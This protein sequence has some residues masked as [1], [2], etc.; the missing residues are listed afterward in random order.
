[1]AG[2]LGQL[3]K[4]GFLQLI[5][6]YGEFAIS[7][8][9]ALQRGKNALDVRVGKAERAEHRAKGNICPKPASLVGVG[10]YGRIVIG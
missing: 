10:G 8:P 1:M 4:S 3:L 5:G 9:M 6:S 2:Q 7:V